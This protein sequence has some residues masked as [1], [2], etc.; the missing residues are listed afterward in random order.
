MTDTW[1]DCKD[2]LPKRNGFYITYGAWREYFYA[3][4]EMAK[5]RWVAGWNVQGVTHWLDGWKPG[6]PLPPPPEVK[7]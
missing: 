5:G 1:I 7:P 4:F 6:D 3:E 2:R